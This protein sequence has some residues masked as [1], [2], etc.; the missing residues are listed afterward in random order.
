MA[1]NTQICVIWGKRLWIYIKIVVG[2]EFAFIWTL[3]KPWIQFLMH[4]A[5]IFAYFQGVDNYKCM[6]KCLCMTHFW[7]ARPFSLFQSSNMLC[8]NHLP[9]P[10]PQA[11]CFAYTCWLDSRVIASQIIRNWLPF[12]GIYCVNS[13]V[14]KRHMHHKEWHS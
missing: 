9:S 5:D 7:V 6:K 10:E 13:Q 11:L 12:V 8:L 3:L 14:P 4:R 1:K 2:D